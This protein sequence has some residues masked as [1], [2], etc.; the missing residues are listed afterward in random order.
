[1]VYESQ[2][3][4]LKLAC[5]IKFYEGYNVAHALDDL[6]E[7]NDPSYNISEHFSCSAV[8]TVYAEMEEGIEDH[9]MCHTIQLKIYMITFLFR[10][11]GRN[12]FLVAVLYH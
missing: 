2:N 11:Y 5:G 12:L 3:H 6:L 4:N 10:L 1:M 9:V 7:M 8:N